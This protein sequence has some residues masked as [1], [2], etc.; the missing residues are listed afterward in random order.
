[1]E[2]SAEMLEAVKTGNVAQVKKL[3]GADPG[4]ANARAESGESAILLSLYYGQE[5][6][7]ELLLSSGAELNVYEAAAA[8]ELERLKSL[9][10][11]FPDLVRSFSHDG[12]TPLHLAA[13]FGQKPVVDCLLAAGAAINEIS[14]NPSALRPIHSAVAHRQPEAALAVTRALIAAGAEVNVTQEAGWTP[15]HSASLNGRLP[16]VRVLLEAGASTEVRAANGQTPLTL[17]A[18]KNHKD[19]VALLRQHGAQ[20]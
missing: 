17:A 16:L 19:V 5:A 15:L 4:L 8:G 12:F 6:I 2:R 7:K 20:A 9:I 13:F 14:R 1:M 18:S 3:L 10:A 11:T